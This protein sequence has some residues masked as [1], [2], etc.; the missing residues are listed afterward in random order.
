MAGPTAP[1]ANAADL[2]Y[3]QYSAE[4]RNY[5]DRVAESLRDGQAPRRYYRNR[6]SEVYR[7]LIPPDR[8]VLEIGCGLGDLLASVRPRRGVGIDLSGEMIDRARQRHPELTFLAAD[9]HTFDLG[10]KFDYIICSDLV[11]DLW[12]VQAALNNIHRHCHGSTRVIV[13]LYSRVWELPR[14]VA[15]ATGAARRLLAQSWLTADDMANLLYLADFDLIRTSPEII[16]PFHVPG[17]SG[18][19]NRGVVRLWPFHLLSMTYVMVC[20]PRPVEGSGHDAVV[21]VVVPARNEEG[22]VPAIFDRTPQ[23]GAGT[24]LIFV[25]GNSSDDTYSAIER[26]LARRP[27]VNARL[28]KQPGKGKGDAV[29]TGFAAASGELFMILDADL[30]V[31]PEDL[32]RFYE[33]WRSGKAEYVNGVRLVYP[34]ETRAMRFINLLGNRFFSI[35][36]SWL[37]GQNIKDTLCGTKVLSR[38]DYEVIAANRSYFGQEDPFGDFDLIFGAARFCLKF[39]DIPIRYRERV[40]GETNIRR[41][42]HGWLL[43]RMLV[44]G[45]FK[46]KFI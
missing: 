44:K 2:R 15:E 9:A 26:E 36:F 19:L 5:W 14:R 21:S 20:R 42:A 4:R 46:L 35:A 31:A 30:T 1:A 40:Y 32:P 7:N 27:G 24:E 10:E 3:E 45:M 28:L 43:I 18:F 22:N 16:F 38:Q 39:V 8:T 17:L 6:L 25:E 34:M 11:N 12:D 29:R 23:M 41:W 13:N 33:A 37:L